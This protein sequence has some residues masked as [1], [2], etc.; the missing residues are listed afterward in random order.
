MIP[1]ALALFQSV[2]D[3]SQAC[4]FTELHNY[5]QCVVLCY[6]LQAHS[7]I[8]WIGTRECEPILEV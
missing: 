8:V 3:L 1:Q 5:S 4:A 2:A 7:S 6:Q